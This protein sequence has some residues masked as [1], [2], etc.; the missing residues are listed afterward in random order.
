[1]RFDRLSVNCDVPRDKSVPETGS[2]EQQS[3][4]SIG[5]DF[6][7]IKLFSAETIIF[8]EPA[9]SGLILLTRYRLIFLS[10]RQNCP[11]ENHE[12]GNGDA[13]VSQD[14]D[15]RVT[16]PKNESR[17]SLPIGCLDSV[18]IRDNHQ[19]MI[20]TK[21][22][23]SYVC[24]FHSADQT[25]L[26]FK[27][28]NDAIS[29]QSKLD[30]LFCFALWKSAVACKAA[31]AASHVHSNGS[32]NGKTSNGVCNVSN[33]SASHENGSIQNSDSQNGTS[34]SQSV[35]DSKTLDL[36][37][38]LAS[39]VQHLEISSLFEAD[40]S[41]SVV[42][43]SSQDC[44]MSEYKR[45]QFDCIPDAWR[46]SDLN[47]DY[48][49]IGT[50]PQYLIVPTAVPDEHLKEV[51]AFRSFRRVA[52]VVWRSQKNGCVIVR[53]S[54]PEVGWFGWRSAADEKMLDQIV[55]SSLNQHPAISFSSKKLL[56]IDARSY[57]AAVANRAK[58]GG[59]ECPEYYPAA[60]VMFMGLANIHSI[61]KSF[62]SLRTI[63]QNP[64]PDSG[65]WLTQVDSTRW[66][67]H[68]SGLLKS[69]IIVV[70]AIVKDERPVLVHCSDGWDRTP[71]ITSLAELLLD[72]F[73]RT[74]DGFTILINR[75]WI[76]FG[77]KF[78]ERCMNAPAV[79]DPN[80]KCPVFLQWVDCVHQ[81]W[82]QFPSAFE[83]NQQ[84][85]VSLLH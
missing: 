36:V 70:D 75:E 8:G 85:L 46:I 79:E 26:W 14:P 60:E 40:R 56:I 2:E 54:Q 45:M 37:R 55:K 80:E 31:S 47:K 30:H 38:E 53:S 67:H 74:L 3:S 83:F 13:A 49:S 59:C 11:H 42:D 18:E 51:S 1:M 77:H 22:V 34:P 23:K 6:A 25:S 48:K 15:C 84:F 28:V 27:R 62:Q 50:Y 43:Q 33:G 32:V 12:N 19:L 58:G 16:N 52:S 63:C 9:V 82:K 5:T 64:V 39:L 65:M 69:A 57:A 10:R 17:F 61:R 66:L 7:P 76:E 71:Q 72:P 44:L 4:L 21:H 73:Y 68:I 29:Y 78:S 41:D 35:R 24:Q 20:L 81:I